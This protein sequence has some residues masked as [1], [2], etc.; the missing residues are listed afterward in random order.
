MS[1]NRA[2]LQIS[3]S[4]GWHSFYYYILKRNTMKKLSVI[5]AMLMLLG[6]SISSCS[7]GA[8]MGTKKHGVSVGTQAH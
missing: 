7:A 4:K 8:H 5:A 6:A 2:K 3:L 1:M